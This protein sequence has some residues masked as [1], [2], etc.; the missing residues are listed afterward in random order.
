MIADDANHTTAQKGGPLVEQY[1]L[2]VQAAADKRGLDY[3]Y[4]QQ[5]HVNEDYGTKTDGSNSPLVIVPQ[6]G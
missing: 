2:A 1:Q 6:T 4:V 3:N 5:A